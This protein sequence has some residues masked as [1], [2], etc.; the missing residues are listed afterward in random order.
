MAGGITQEAAPEKAS[1][2]ACSPDSRRGRGR[3]GYET[4][5]TAAVDATEM[6]REVYRDLL[7]SLAVLAVVMVLATGFALRMGKRIVSAIAQLLEVAQALR[8]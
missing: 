3:E 1:P 4:V 5:V 2:A 8:A 6:R 7:K